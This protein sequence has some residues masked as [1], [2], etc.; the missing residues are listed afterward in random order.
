MNKVWFN[1]GVRKWHYEVAGSYDELT[2]KQ[3]YQIAQVLVGQ[4]SEKEAKIRLLFI[5]L[6]HHPYCKWLILHRINPDDLHTHL[7]ALTE[8]ITSANS[9][10]TQ[11]PLPKIR[12][13][14]QFRFWKKIIWYGAS[15]RLKNISFEEFCQADSFFMAYAKT[16]DPTFLHQLIAVLYRPEVEN[17]N[18][19][20]PDFKGDRREKFNSFTVDSRI[21]L[22]S[23]LPQAKQFA[24]FLFYAGSRQ[25]LMVEFPDLF[26]EGSGKADPAIWAKIL[27][28]VAGN[29][30][31]SDPI[32]EAQARAVFFD[33]QENYR[34][35]QQQE[36]HL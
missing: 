33:L 23:Q 14:F 21:R 28:R 26:E 7:F 29:L 11:N 30:S 18:P 17:Y 6:K 16:Q 19:E 5:L 10:L 3:V 35:Q 27:R 24:I 2:P 34:E 32:A 4:W 25:A 9:P 15:D 36:A 8:F 20:H 13:G 1:D 31:T 12:V 22:A